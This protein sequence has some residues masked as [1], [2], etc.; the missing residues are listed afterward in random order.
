MPELKKHKFE[1]KDKLRYTS[2]LKRIYQEV[3]EKRKPAGLDQEIM[4]PYVTP[5]WWEGLTTRIRGN[6]E[7]AESKH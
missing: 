2:P 4:P 3:Q 6:A 5:L 7:Q 1:T